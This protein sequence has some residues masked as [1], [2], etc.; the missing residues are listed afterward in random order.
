MADGDA[1]VV[2]RETV[3]RPAVVGAPD[4][5]VVLVFRMRVMDREAG[6]TLREVLFDPLS[7]AATPFFVGMPGFR[8]KL[9]MAGERSDEFLEL[10][11]W[12]STEDADRFVTVLESLLESFDFAVSASFDVAADDSIDEYVAARSISWR[13]AATRR[14]AEGRWRRIGGVALP[15]AAAFGG[16]YLAGKR[17]PRAGPDD[18]RA[19]EEQT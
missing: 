10:Y 2:Y 4:D 3:L 8:R 15:V 13:D 14:R 16:G 17:R 5:G 7:N 9:W 12:A 11:E 1:F 19:P 6:G 18:A